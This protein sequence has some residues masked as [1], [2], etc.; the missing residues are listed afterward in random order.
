VPA[1]PASDPLA[2][3][4]AAVVEAAAELGSEDA[5]GLTLERPPKR[6]LGDYST[7]AA[8]LLAGGLRAAPRE[9]AERLRPALAERLGER[10]ERIEVA[11]P[12]FLNLFMS[13]EW[14]REATAAMLAAG[15][16]LGR[17]AA[18]T[19]QRV[20]LEFVSANPTGPVTVASGRGAAYGDSLARVLE[21]NGH[22]V[23]REYYVN[24]AGSQI[25][26]FTR[27]VAARMAGE[28]PP[29]DGYAGEYVTELAQELK[30]AG[31]GPDDLDALGRQAIEAMR[32][33]IEASLERFGV[34]FDT[35][36]SER[37]LRESGAPDRTLEQLNERGHV[38]NSEGALWLRTTEFGDDKDRVLIRSDGEPTY[39]APDIAYHLDKFERGADRLIDVLGA[40][41]HGY[42][43]RMRAALAALGCDPEHFEAA[44]MQMVSVVEGGQRSRMSKRKGD[45]VT[46]DE[47]IDDIGADAA[48]FFMLQRSHDSTVDLDLELARS[49]SQENPVYYVQYAHARIASILRKAAEEGSGGEPQEI[50][51]AAGS[52]AALGAAAEASELALVRRLLELPAETRAAAERRA[53]HRLCAY[54]MAT[55][56][57][58]H[59]FY[60]D[61]RVVG[62]E[63]EVEAARLG[64][65]LAA[66]RTIAITLGLLGISAPERM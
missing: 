37:A 20:L 31:A 9:I 64:L 16:G 28:Q 13:V 22:T 48:R 45:F 44:I 24:D 53:P 57:D 11:G 42:V 61:C 25:E 34:H 30:G 65:S 33:R 54:A 36:S 46:L 55:A 32:E 47:L 1:P 14:H 50:A 43:P 60:R 56:A 29:E 59:A 26:L 27:S 5:A 15:D 39:F 23:E 49:Q 19:P 7:N 52:E 2:A 12:G 8:M 38:Y 51:T 6:E 40:D 18:E 63:P 66:S 62:A 17:N 4:R 35:W 10:A 58:F 41:H 21:F 3:L